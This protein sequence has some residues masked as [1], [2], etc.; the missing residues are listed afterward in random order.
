[1]IIF[2]KSR[3]IDQAV[4]AGL[5]SVA[6]QLLPPQGSAVPNICR[7]SSN[8]SCLLAARIAIADLP[9]FSPSW[10][11]QW[12]PSSWFSV[13][14]PILPT[15]FSTSCSVFPG[16]RFVTRIAISHQAGVWQE[17]VWV[18]TTS[19]VSWRWLKQ[20]AWMENRLKTRPKSDK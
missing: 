5:H 13:H 1:L 8:Y 10:V 7:D 16:L 14:P 18:S 15:L 12:C 20:F 11:L 6:G 4:V 2:L 9:P 3:R 19:S 17:V